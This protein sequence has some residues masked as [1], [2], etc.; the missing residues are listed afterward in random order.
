MSGT[1][2]CR[3]V[4]KRTTGVI[5]DVNYSSSM[6]RTPEYWAGWILAQYQWYSCQS[7]SVIY[8]C[9]SFDELINL[10]YPLHEAHEFKTFKILDERLMSSGISLYNMIDS[11][12]DVVNIKLRFNTPIIEKRSRPENRER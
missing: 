11:N 2:L 8:S 9:I 7:F 4:F 10:Y 5:P 1:E 3:D 12:Y 6:H